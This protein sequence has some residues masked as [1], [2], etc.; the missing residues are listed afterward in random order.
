MPDRNNLLFIL[1]EDQGY[2]SMGCSGDF[3]IRIPNLDRLVSTGMLFENIFCASP[4]CSPARASILTG[5]VPSQHGVQ[6][7][8]RGGN[9]S[10]YRGEVAGSANLIQ[11]D[12]GIEYLA[13]Q[14]G[15]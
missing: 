1:T 6:D 11:D 7:F 14:R 4:V 8:L 9:T 3:E 10:L 2:W 15:Y 13:G 12:G 5:R